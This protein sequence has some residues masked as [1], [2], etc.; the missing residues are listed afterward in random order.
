MPLH[1][2]GSSLKYWNLEGKFPKFS[3]FVFKI[4]WKCLSYIL[5]LRTTALTKY[6]LNIHRISA[7]LK[8]WIIMHCVGKHVHSILI[9]WHFLT[10]FPSFSY[11]QMILLEPFLDRTSCIKKKI[12]IQ[13]Y[14]KHIK[15]KGE[16]EGNFCIF[17][18]STVSV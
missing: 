17:R 16:K 18:W 14:T 15:G 9:L 7:E 11:I 2:S 6:F 12:T 8:S 13:L 5:S 4:I 3:H 10:L 1:Y